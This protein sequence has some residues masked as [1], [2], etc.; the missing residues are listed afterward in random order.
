MTMAQILNW[1]KSIGDRVE[2]GE[3][4]LEIETDKVNYVI[5]AEVSGVVKAILASVGDKI[6]VGGVVAIIGEAD[7]LIDI[8]LYKKREEK[9]LSSIDVH[10]EKREEEIPISSQRETKH[11][12]ASPVAKKMCREI[13][14]DL[15]SVKGSGLSGRIRKE[16]VERY[17]SEFKQVKAEP[18]IPGEPEISEI[19]PMTTMRKTIAKRLTQ[20]F[21]NAPHFNLG[22]EVDMTEAKKLKETIREKVEGRVGIPPSLNDIFIRAVAGTLRDHPLLNA[23]LN[24]E[25][26]EVLGDI[27]IGLAVTLDNG[28]IVPAIEKADQKELWEITRNRKYLVDRARQGLLSLA[29]IERGTFTISNLGMYDITFFT[30]IL[31]PPQT[32]IL[33][34]GKAVERPVVHHGTVV[35]RPIVEMS[36]AIDHRVVDGFVG[37]MFLQDLK[38][39]LENPY[40]WI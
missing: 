35:I 33:S 8:G 19:I 39:G 15:A 26:I 28:L 27:N 20:S 23:R 21:R 30:S 38:N 10:V 9:E 22:T 13:G 31:N 17:I 34:I 40:L 18:T 7:E 3:P 14:I 24:G 2:V 32:G 4:L 16:D 37:A 29:E 5:E 25:Q 1:F 36:L 11:I 6:P 12:L